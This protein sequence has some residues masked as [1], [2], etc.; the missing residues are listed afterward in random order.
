M[1]ETS[2]VARDL[3]AL[4]RADEPAFWRR[5]RS[6]PIELNPF[7]VAEI[8]AARLRFHRFAPALAQLFPGSGWDGEI[9][10][11]LVDY[12][13]PLN[14]R[15]SF[16]V[17]ADHA[18]PMTGSVKARGGVHELLRRIETIAVD[19]GLIRLNDNYAHLASAEARL[20][21]SEH[22]VAVASTGNLGFSIGLVA[23]AF[24]LRAQVHMSRDAK[25][26]KKARLVDIGADVIEHDCD[27]HDT[28]SRGREHARQSGAQFID[29]EHSVDLFA[30]Y[31][32]A[33]RELE[34]QLIERSIVPT[35]DAPLVVYL[36]CGVGGAPGGIT[37][38]L[39]A[40]Y[41]DAVICFFVEPTASACMLAALALGDG[42][43]LSVYDIGLT[44]ATLAD[45][46]AVP[47]ASSLVI[48][49]IGNQ[50]DGVV[51][52]PDRVMVEWVAR[53]WKDAQLRLEPSAAAA[54]AAADLVIRE[55]P[56]LSTAHHVAW[57]TGG[58][59]LPDNEFA[60][61]LQLDRL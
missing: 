39:K 44:N 42:R 32:V 3:I 7:V 49:L 14:E 31:A 55:D 61:L 5:T 56:S 21:F 23:R 51:A 12:P 38:G 26:W 54:L 34:R 4:L 25:A 10:S 40:I 53:A 60:V 9:N 15:V 11:S 1:I 29:D 17:K 16:L 13:E 41:G 52:L 46:L 28:V 22:T 50:I 48:E 43:S 19:R 37:F 18:L 30:G 35:A 59:L 57:T 24:G 2:L 45:G 6:V 20:Q 27:F 8:E 33:A 58:A 36:P 47:Q